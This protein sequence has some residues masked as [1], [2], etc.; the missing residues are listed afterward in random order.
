MKKA[1]LTSLVIA[2][3]CVN[4][5]AAAN[6]QTQSGQTAIE[7]QTLVTP[8]QVHN[9]L[10]A[11][12]QDTTATYEIIISK[13]YDYCASLLPQTDL[14]LEH[15]YRIRN[16]IPKE[17]MESDMKT[18]APKY[19]GNTFAVILRQYLESEQV[20]VGGR[21]INIIATNHRGEPFDLSKIVGKKE[22]FLIFGG[23]GCMGDEALDY[24]KE[25][26]EAL[27]TKKAEIIYI[28]LETKSE[29]FELECKHFQTLWLK[30]CDMKGDFSPAKIAYN[31]QATPTCVNID[32]KGEIICADQGLS[33]EFLQKIFNFRRS[34]TLV[35]DVNEFFNE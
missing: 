4:S 5:L 28:S 1:I 18:L 15:I 7:N 24:L 27:N 16:Y 25:L 30:I 19:N 10:N 33:I 3:W 22:I 20:K 8:A 34:N 6:T 23:L 2:L 35:R 29:E 17:R 26:Y 11:M 31:V 32:K 21:Y 9:Q 14:T 12:W 13:V